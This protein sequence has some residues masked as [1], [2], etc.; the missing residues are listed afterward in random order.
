MIS[1]KNLQC[2]QCLLLHQDKYKALIHFYTSDSL[3]F[4]YDKNKLEVF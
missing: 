3:G 4:D 1:N 2:L